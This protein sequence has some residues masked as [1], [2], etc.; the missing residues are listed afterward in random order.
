MVRRYG[1]YGGA[2]FGSSYNRRGYRGGRRSQPRPNIFVQ[3]INKAPSSSSEQDVFKWNRSSKEFVVGSFSPTKFNNVI[4]NFQIQEINRKIKRMDL[5]N[6]DIGT[7]MVLGMCL[8]FLC[9]PLGVYFYIRF[10]IAGNVLLALLCFFGGVIG[11]FC[12]IGCSAATAEQNMKKSLKE[13]ETKIN[14][15]FVN[16]NRKHRSKGIA[17]SVG[18]YGSWISVKIIDRGIMNSHNR[19]NSSTANNSNPR[20]NNTN[21][22]LPSIPQINRPAPRPRTPT[23]DRHFPIVPNNPVRVRPSSNVNALEP[24][25]IG[26]G[27]IIRNNV[28]AYKP[29]AVNRF[30]DIAPAIVKVEKRHNED[31]DLEI[32]GINV[33]RD[34]KVDDNEKDYAKRMNYPQF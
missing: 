29:P 16:E 13:R 24:Q 12:C 17:F 22:L 32:L 15:F 21:R 20:P 31:D 18:T 30:G 7:S 25:N 3:S 34:V 5:S 4:T 19:F 2:R 33:P 1:R 28:N 23:G 27:G 14:R 11:V 10:L 9:L 6:G 8:G 26:V